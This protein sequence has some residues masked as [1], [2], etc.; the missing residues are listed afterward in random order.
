[1]YV[2][3]ALTAGL[4]A[5]PS[6]KKTPQVL[7]E[8]EDVAAAVVRQVV[9]GESAQLILPPRMGFVTTLRAWPHWL[10]VYA[11]GLSRDLIVNPK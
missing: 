5:S 1:M 3:T 9:R 2:R 6:W 10:Q 4:I 8:A 11:R 7:L